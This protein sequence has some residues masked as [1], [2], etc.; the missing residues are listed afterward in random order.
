M[1]E[2]FSTDL[3]RQ[4]LHGR[5]GDHHI[6]DVDVPKRLRCTERSQ[7]HIEEDEGNDEDSASGKGPAHNYQ[8]SLRLLIG[9]GLFFGCVAV[10]GNHLIQ[11]RPEKR[12]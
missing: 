9:S 4:C 6:P 12:I 5:D 7:S 8:L 2:V 3:Y 10:I 1:T 11:G